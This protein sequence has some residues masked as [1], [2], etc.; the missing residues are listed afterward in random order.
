MLETS[1]GLFDAVK[2]LDDLKGSRLENEDDIVELETKLATARQ[3]ITDEETTKAGPT[4][5]S[6]PRQIWPNT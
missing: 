5:E 1:Q 4:M 3:A 2:L 6:M